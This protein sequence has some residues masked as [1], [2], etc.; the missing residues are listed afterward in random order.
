MEFKL[1]GPLEVRQS[2]NA[3]KVGGP[4]Q[5]AVLAALLSRANNTASMPYLLEAVWE[6]PPA[7]P[8]SNIRTYVCGLR[9]RLCA[10]GDTRITVRDC[11]YVL[12]TQAGEVDVQVFLALT[13]SADAAL[14]TGDVAGAADRFRRAL[15]L[16]RG[17]PLEG[18]DVGPRLRAEMTLLEDRRLYAAERYAQ[19]ASQLHRY[20][21]VVSVL[22]ELAA[23]YPMREGLWS[24]LMSVLSASG[25]RAEAL[26]AYREARAH[27]IGELGLEPGPRLRRLHQQALAAD[28]DLAG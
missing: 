25:R 7:A 22:R 26:A 28:A 11:G 10:C 3:V 6:K 9:R 21:D 15:G 18:L 2:G 20:D 1:L 8:E 4:R 13:D 12:L 14:L 16:W 23:D 5:R 19:A 27:L 17:R 24:E